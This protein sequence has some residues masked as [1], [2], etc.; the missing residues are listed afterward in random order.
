LGNSS[1]LVTTTLFQV[2][3][4]QLP[5]GVEMQALADYSKGPPTQ[6][7]MLSSL[8]TQ[9]MPAM[10]AMSPILTVL[11]TLSALKDFAQDPL[12]PL[13]V[14]ALVTALGNAIGLINP[15]EFVVA[16]KSIL[17]LVIGY[18][19]AFIQTMSGLLA[20]Q[21][22]IDLSIAQGNPDLMAS[23]QQSSNNASVSIQQLMLSLGPIAPV[24][25]LI[26][27]FIAISG[28]SIALPSIASLQ[29]EKDVA[30]AVQTLGTMLADLQQAL[31]A[32]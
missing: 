11:N 25:T 24:M 7:G 18:L 14:A 15:A 31:E 6:A 13:K 17:Q 4:V 22:S 3:T 27:P 5:F 16:I 29:G 12:N 9:V 1:S 32:L 28:A 19:E 8:L 2:P 10:A 30:K 26:Q 23:L 20:F 21:A